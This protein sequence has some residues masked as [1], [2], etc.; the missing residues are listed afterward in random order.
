M[1]IPRGLQIS[2]VLGLVCALVSA[3]ANPTASPRPVPA[4]PRPGAVKV[5]ENERV[6]VWRITFKKGVPTP[7]HKHLHD[8][9]TV[10]LQDVTIQDTSVAGKKETWDAKAG[11]TYFSP[12][13]MVHIEEGLSEPPRDAIVVEL[14]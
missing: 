13:G 5:L 3:S 11:D 7:L 9:V 12:K 10:F 2:A 14:K 1:S 4:Y 6:I 8:K